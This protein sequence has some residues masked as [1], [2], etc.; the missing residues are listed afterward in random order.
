[1]RKQLN[2]R[3]RFFQLPKSPLRSENLREIK[4]VNCDWI[5]GIDF[6]LE[7]DCKITITVSLIAKERETGERS[8][9]YSRNQYDRGYF[10]SDRELLRE[11]RR[12]AHHGVCHEIDE[13]L[14]FKGV[15][16]FDPH[17]K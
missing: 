5:T 13:T 10:I 3:K 6:D 16:L 7:P 8:L 4:F 11:V 1:M 12:L 2:S 9:V 14:Q 17:K 15:R